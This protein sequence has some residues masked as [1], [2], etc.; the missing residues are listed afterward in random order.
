[1][2]WVLFIASKIVFPIASII[3]F[4]YSLRYIVSPRRFFLGL[5]DKVY[6]SAISND[7]MANVWLKELLNDTCV[8]DGGHLYGDEDD[9]ISDI[10][11][12][13][14][15][16]NKLTRFGW[17]FTKFLSKVLGANHSLESI[18]EN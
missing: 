17:G 10:T 2:K 9:T 12:R 6:R 7:Q 3:G 4:V 1:V 16:D 14:E 8:K 11:G 15:R 5:N 18:D 13:N